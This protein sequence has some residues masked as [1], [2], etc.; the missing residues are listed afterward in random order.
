MHTACGIA[1][2]T[3]YTVVQFGLYEKLKGS[4]LDKRQAE[5]AAGGES[6]G[7]GLPGWQYSALGM[8]SGGVAAAVT[9]PLDVIKTRLMTQAG[10]GPAVPRGATAAGGGAAGGRE[11]LYKGAWDCAVRI[12]KEEGPAVL[13]SGIK[14]RV[15]WISLG[16]AIYIGFFEWA[17]PTFTSAGAAQ[18]GRPE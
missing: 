3:P 18:Q 6:A 8:L 13:L 17:K 16:G 1:C 4:L 7:T 14:P 5:A 2:L 9:T 15:A 11:V 10:A 12:W